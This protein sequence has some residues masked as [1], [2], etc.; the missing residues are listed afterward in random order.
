MRSALALWV[1]GLSACTAPRQH[2]DT[3]IVAT[4]VPMPPPLPQVQRPGLP[5]LRYAADVGSP[6]AVDTSATGGW[7]ETSPWTFALG[8]LQQHGYLVSTDFTMLCGSAD[9]LPS[10]SGGTLSTQACTRILA[11]GT[12]DLPDPAALDAPEWRR[13]YYGAFSGHLLQPGDPASPLLLF[14]HGENKNEL[15]EGMQYPN[16]INLDATDYSGYAADGTYVDAWDAYNAFIGSVLVPDPNGALAADPQG[17]P[18][19]VQDNGPVVWPSMGYLAAD[20]T[21]TSEGVRHPS[22]I[23][24]AGDL[25]LF[26]L[27]M[28]HGDDPTRHGGIKVARAP[29]SSAGAPGSFRAY[30]QGD[31]TEPCLPDGYRAADLHASLA[32]P[33]PRTSLILGLESADDVR[34]SVAEVVPSPTGKPLFVGVE[35]HVDDANGWWAALRLSENLV[36]WSPPYAIPGAAASTWDAG[37][38]NYPVLLDR[39]GWSNNRVDLSD[40]Y[41]V[42]TSASQT[43]LLHLAVTVVPG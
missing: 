32:Q 14:A 29:L 19:Q 24:F 20:G 41:V 43:N 6:V 21:K 1:L 27:D 15:R 30:F 9:S 35:E 25:Y 36:D 8:P 4:P 31:F 3:Q 26:Y 13:N 37:T 2:P 34:F 38:L 22:S 33:G 42:G 10:V 5:L 11:G 23:V 40:F 16:T 28:S 18:A 17:P 39:D 12:T 7:T